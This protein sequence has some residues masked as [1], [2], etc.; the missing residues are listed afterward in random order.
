MT[1]P[2]SADE[3]ALFEAADLLVN[4]KPLSSAEYRAKQDRLD[5]WLMGRASLGAAQVPSEDQI[6]RHTLAAKDCPPDS[7][8]LLVYAVKRLQAR[9]ATELTAERSAESQLFLAAC[10]DLGRIAADLGLD[11]DEGGA[12]PILEAIR[13]LRIGTAGAA[14]VPGGSDDKHPR[15]ILWDS[16][17]PDYPV[18]WTNPGRPTREGEVGY[19][20]YDLFSA[21]C[22]AAEPAGAAQV[23]SLSGGRI[24]EL[25]VEH[26]LD[27]DD[28]EGFARIIEREVRATLSQP[29]QQG[30]K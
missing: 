10:S 13:K 20:R 30:Q 1:T 22:E 26:G 28:P 25:W 8:V 7:K 27:E 21:A 29:S 23:P 5:G 4:G 15:F 3:R 6:E 2:S 17:H 19:V 24:T 18:E 11:S 9:A 16:L 14:Q 12:E